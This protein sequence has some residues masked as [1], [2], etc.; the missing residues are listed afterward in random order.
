M[1]GE[2]LKDSTIVESALAM[3]G[4]SLTSEQG[5]F[6][7]LPQRAHTIRAICSKPPAETA[8]IWWS[9]VSARSWGEL[10]EQEVTGVCE[11]Q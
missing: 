11:S 10:V 3:D 2:S 7:V 4:H 8:L 5:G 9:K 1:K 6:V